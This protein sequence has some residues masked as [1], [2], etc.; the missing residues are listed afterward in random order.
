[1]QRPSARLVQVVSL[2]PRRHSASPRRHPVLLAQTFRGGINGT[3]TDPT[4]AAIAGASVVALQTDTGISHTTL[5][6][7]G[8]EFLFQDLPLG[9][10]SVTAGFN[11]FQTLKT[12]KVTV[13]AG[14]IYTLPSFSNSPAPA[15]P[16]KSTQPA[17]P[18]TH[19]H[20]A[21]YGARCKSRSRPPLNGRDFTQMI[22]LT[23]G[24]AGYSGG[25]YGSLNG[26][27]ANQ[28]NWQIDGVDNNDLWH[29]IPAVNQGGVSGIAGII[30]PLDAVDQFSA[31]TQ[32]GPEGGRNPGGTVNMTLRSGT[33]QLHGTAYYFNRNEAFGAKSPS[34]PQA[35][36]P[37][38]QHW[39][40]PRR[41]I[42]QGQAVR[43]YH[44]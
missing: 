30:L 21:N 11:G 20:H 12:D 39:L 13:S 25:G 16:S 42:P 19:H 37:Q 40:L 26:T 22:S 27:R 24:Y 17:W 31:Q 23:A 28:M 38:L 10:Y 43:L 15:S 4:G 41:P 14:I 36:G 9:N 29:N 2:Q 7:S 44:L 1:M 35:E 18:S 5:S 3:V 33:N 34:P 8:G 6:S 32:S